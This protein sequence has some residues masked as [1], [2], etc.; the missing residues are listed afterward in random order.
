MGRAP[1]VRVEPKKAQETALELRGDLAQI[2][3]AARS[4]RQFDRQLV[5]KEIV[6]VSQRLDGEEVQRGPDWAPPVGVAAKEAGAR[7]PGS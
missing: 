5:A 3:P 2:R 4:G 6:K 7:L 1:A